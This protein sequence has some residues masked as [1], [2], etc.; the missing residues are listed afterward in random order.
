MEREI[1]VYTSEKTSHTYKGGANKKFKLGWIDKSEMSITLKMSIW[2]HKYQI[3]EPHEPNF[4]LGWHGMD[5]SP[6]LK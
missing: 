3:D 1:F 2:V 6:N 5:S 4:C